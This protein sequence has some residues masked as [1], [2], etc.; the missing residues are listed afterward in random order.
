MSFPPAAAFRS[1]RRSSLTTALRLRRIVRTALGINL[2]IEGIE[3][4][5]Q[6]SYLLARQPAAVGQGWL[7]GRPVPLADIVAE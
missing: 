3:T 6:A 2:I 7:F 5:A 1:G 4:E